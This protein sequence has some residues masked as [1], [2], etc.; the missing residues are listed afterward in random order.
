[1]QL[2]K[3]I[4]PAQRRQAVEEH[5]LKDDLKVLELGREHFPRFTKDTS[6][7]DAQKIM[8]DLKKKVQEQRDSLIRK[9]QGMGDNEAKMKDIHAAAERILSL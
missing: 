3:S 2:Y 5:S 8:K 1:M 6:D 9:Y 4:S 7:E